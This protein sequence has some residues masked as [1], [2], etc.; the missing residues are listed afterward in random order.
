MWFCQT[1][2]NVKVMVVCFEQFNDLNIIP[3]ATGC[4]SMMGCIILPNAPYTVGLF[5]NAN[6]IMGKITL[7]QFVYAHINVYVPL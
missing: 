6:S 3:N 2:K 7:C 4:G 1:N 5:I